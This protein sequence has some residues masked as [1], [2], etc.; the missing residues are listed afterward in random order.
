MLGEHRGSRLGTVVRGDPAGMGRRMQW[1]GQ[2]QGLA[3]RILLR[4]VE[5]VWYVW[6]CL[7]FH[8]RKPQT[9]QKWPLLAPW[10]LPTQW[11]DMR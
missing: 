7:A 10:P 3:G 5:G 6:A 4:T 9:T 2:V 11:L 8:C 1:N